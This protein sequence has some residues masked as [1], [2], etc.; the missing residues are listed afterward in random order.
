MATEDRAHWDEKYLDAQGRIITP[1]LPERFE[2][3]AASFVS[4]STALE[5]ACG[6]GT[7][8]VWLA[9]QGVRVAAYDISPVAISAANGLADAHGVGDRCTFAIHDFDHGLPPG[10]PVDLVVCNMFRAASLDDA[11]VERLRPGGVL[12]IAALSEVGAKPGRFRVT[13]GELPN[14]FPSFEVLASDEGDGVAWL[15]ARKSQNEGSYGQL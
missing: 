14:A 3:Y 5:I 2:P 6:A 10:D 11:I 4:A 1:S 8:A 9:Q 7:T 13:P 12:A 15:L